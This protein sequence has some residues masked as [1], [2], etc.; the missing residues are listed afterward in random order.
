M[1]NK[2]KTNKNGIFAPLLATALFFA[3]LIVLVFGTINISASANQEGADATI[4][5]IQKA[6][7]LCYATEGYYPPSLE[8]IEERYGVLVDYNRYVVRYDIFATNV[9][10]SIIVLPR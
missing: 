6:A 9:T 7:V 8:Y 1:Y 5:A 3:M 10:P 4:K 2:T